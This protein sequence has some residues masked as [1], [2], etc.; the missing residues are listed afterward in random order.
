MRDSR[1]FTCEPNQQFYFSHSTNSL[2][3][4]TPHA[5]THPL[6]QGLGNH[7]LKS[8]IRPHPTEL[9]VLAPDRDEREANALISGESHAMSER[10]EIMVS[11]FPHI[12]PMSHISLVC[13]PPFK[14]IGFLL[15]SSCFYLVVVDFWL[16]VWDEEWKRDRKRMEKMESLAGLLP[17]LKLAPWG[18]PPHLT[19]SPPSSLPLIDPKSWRM[20]CE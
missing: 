2:S 8:L 10:R 16:R 19:S 17:L 14:F 1:L 20:S 9:K 7:G 12:R 18:T 15:L 5:R 13:I 11:R 3:L 6:I 4:I